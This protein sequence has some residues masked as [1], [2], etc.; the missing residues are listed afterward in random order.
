[1]ARFFV[2]A[3]LLISLAS[4]ARADQSTGAITSTD[5]S[6]MP[7]YVMLTFSAFNGSCPGHPIWPYSN[8]LWFNGGSANESVFTTVLATNIAGKQ[9]W[10]LWDSYSCQIVDIRTQ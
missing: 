5:P 2:V 9:V 10:L 8:W 6:F 7:G 4:A 3:A 1:M